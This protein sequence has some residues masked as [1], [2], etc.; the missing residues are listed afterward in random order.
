MPCKHALGLFDGNGTFFAN[1][2]A[3]VAT[4]TLI[5]IDGYGFR[6]L[7]FKNFNRTHI[8][9][10]SAACAFFFVHNGIESH[11]DTPPFIGNLHAVELFNLISDTDPTAYIN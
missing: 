4:E 8:H 7:Q 5:R 10:L 2:N 9:T 6:V 1:F 3:A 11:S